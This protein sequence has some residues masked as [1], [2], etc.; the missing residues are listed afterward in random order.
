VTFSFHE[1]AEVS[2]EEG[3]TRSELRSVQSGS[4][5]HNKHITH[6][7]SP[8]YIFTTKHKQDSKHPLERKPHLQSCPTAFCSHTWFAL[9]CTRELHRWASTALHSG[10]EPPSP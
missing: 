4:C 6:D 8:M 3:K 10:T 1:L 2:N 7:V 5:C 9:V